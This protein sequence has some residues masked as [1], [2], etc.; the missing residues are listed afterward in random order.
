MIIFSYIVFIDK[1]LVE[2][3]DF[4]YINCFFLNFISYFFPSLIPNTTIIATNRNIIVPNNSPLKHIY[5]L[6]ISRANLSV[7]FKT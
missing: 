1:D 5:L 6:L 3:Q 7:F 2:T 4:A